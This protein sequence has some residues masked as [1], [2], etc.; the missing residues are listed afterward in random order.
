MTAL[1]DLVIGFAIVEAIALTV[2]HWRTGRGLGPRDFGAALAAGLCLMLALRLGATAAVP[3]T[4]LFALLL[5]LAGTAHAV[6]LWLR[7]RT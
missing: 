1:V 3:A 7:W 5:A 2:Y 4:P 6:D